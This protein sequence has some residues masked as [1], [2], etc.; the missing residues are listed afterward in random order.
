ME[1]VDNPTRKDIQKDVIFLGL[2]VFVNK[3]KPDTAEVLSRLRE[4]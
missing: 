2:L 1:N 3:L 4:N